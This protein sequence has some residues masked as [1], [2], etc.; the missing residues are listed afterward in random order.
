MPEI[1][2]NSNGRFSEKL[3]IMMVDSTKDYKSE[4]LDENITVFSSKEIFDE[5]ITVFSSKD[6]VK[7]NILRGIRIEQ[8]D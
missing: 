6:L 4:I 5:N 2:S 7:G 8:R 1:R 3:V